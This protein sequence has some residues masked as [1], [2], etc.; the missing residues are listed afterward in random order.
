MK[1]V[2]PSIAEDA[3]LRAGTNVIMGRISAIVSGNIEVIVAGS[4]ARGTNLAGDSD[5]D[6]F[7]LFDRSV[8]KKFMESEA[9]RTAKQLVK[10]RKNESYTV[11]YAEHPYARLVLGDMGINIDLVPAYKITDAN[12]MGTSVDRTQLHNEFINRNL[13]TAQ[14][15]DVRVLKALLKAHGIYGAESR[16]EGFSGYLCELMVLNY[17]SILELM[18]G[19]STAGMPLVLQIGREAKEGKDALAKRFGKQFV[20]IDPIDAGRN[21]A[22]NVSEESL[23]RLVMVSRAVLD[24]PSELTFYGR[25]H[26]DANPQN[27]LADV[28]RR[29]GIS[30]HAV[31]IKFKDISEEIIW[32]QAKK[33]ER[34]ISAG[35]EKAGFLPV[36]SFSNVE[37]NTAVV[38]F[39][40][41]AAKKRFRVANGPSAFMGGAAESFEKAHSDAVFMSFSSDRVFAVHSSKTTALD[42]IRD[43]AFNAANAPSQMLKGTMAIHTDSKMPAECARMVY[44]AYVRKTTI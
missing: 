40:M 24:D 14:K 3:A 41:D 19:V 26:S 8:D 37:N 31:T 35:L 6:I 17:G 29:L 4:S 23:A 30:M 32:Q 39:F 42:I 5:I 28:R 25:K 44:S 7:M 13:T 10:G 12:E 33:L 2:T 18:E 9:I 27:M 36:L 16:T 22:A 15:G 1:R 11:K 34:K 20:V 43:V 38:C 21:V